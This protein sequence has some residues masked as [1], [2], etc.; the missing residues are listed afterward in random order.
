LGHPYN[1]ENSEKNCLSAFVGTD[2]ST[3]VML[4]TVPLCPLTVSRDPRFEAKSSYKWTLKIDSISRKIMLF[5]KRVFGSMLFSPVITVYC[6][7]V[8]KYTNTA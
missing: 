1:I 3:S 4:G 8:M 7:N 6:E 2:N 5:I